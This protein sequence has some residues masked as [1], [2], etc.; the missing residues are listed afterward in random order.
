MPLSGRRD[1]GAVTYDTAIWKRSDDRADPSEEFDRRFEESDARY[2]EN[3]APIPELARLADLLEANFPEP[4]PWENLRDSIDG[5]FLY[6]T[7]S[8]DKGPQVEEFIARLA[9]ELDLRCL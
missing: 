1:N 8:Y 5:D 2:P 3:R 7:M 4:T 9:P 6:L